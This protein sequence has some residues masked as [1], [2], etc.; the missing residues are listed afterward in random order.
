[1]SL[2][3]ALHG[4]NPGAA[5]VLQL[6]GKTSTDFAR[7]RDAFV[8][9]DGNLYVFT[10]LGGNNRESYES[11]IAELQTDP[12]YVRDFDDD[13][14]STYATFVFRVPDTATA[15]DR[16]WVI[17]LAKIRNGSL[18]EKT[19]AAVERIKT[20]GIEAAPESVQTI[21]SQL[22]EFLRKGVA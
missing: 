15:E 12:L 2:Y 19:L 14:D 13:F 21:I 18:E 7:F 9:A 22:S 5:F 4:F 3:N 10:R 8:G 11:E 17:R 16:E 6:L 1:M 20:G